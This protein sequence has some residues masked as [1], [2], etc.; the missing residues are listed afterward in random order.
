MTISPFYNDIINYF[1]EL[2]VSTSQH[3]HVYYLTSF[4]FFSV[5]QQLIWISCNLIYLSQILIDA[6]KN[7]RVQFG[8]EI[9]FKY[10][11]SFGLI[12]KLLRFYHIDT[13]L[14]PLN[15]ELAVFYPHAFDPISQHNIRNETDVIAVNKVFKKKLLICI[16]MLTIFLSLSGV[17][18]ST[19]S[20]SFRFVDMTEFMKS[21]G[22]AKCCT[23]AI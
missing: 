15:E 17:F 6:K 21:G 12:N 14:C 20:N 1:E 10:Y 22:S 13:A 9:Y 3:H 16:G 11:A 5:I 19:I 18:I 7:L 2:G 23:L 4:D 8:D